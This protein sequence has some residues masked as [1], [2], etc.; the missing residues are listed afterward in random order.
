MWASTLN[1]NFDPDEEMLGSLSYHYNPKTQKVERRK[2]VN[3]VND[4]V[5]RHTGSNVQHVRL[6]FD[7]DY[8]FSSHID[9][10]I[11]FAMKKGVQVLELDFLDRGT[12]FRGSGTCYAFSH[13]VLGVKTGSASRPVCC[14]N[15]TLHP[16]IYISFKTLRV[17]HF[18]AV[19]VNGGVLEYFLSNCPLL[20]QLSVFNSPNLA[21]LRVCGPSI[22]L[23]YLAIE[24]CKALK[25]IEICDVSLVSFIYSGRKPTLLLQNIPSLVEV[26]VFQHASSCYFNEILSD[27]FTQLPCC[28]SQLEIIKAIP[29]RVSI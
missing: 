2:Y 26:S 27:V 21:K 8:K 17:L 29:S 15:P 7:L 19:A 16:N 4:V 9:K 23:K 14:D 22:A 20:E 12:L 13:E 28:L 18:K 3:W 10:W 11:Q 5:E 6:S 25:S 1:L 24:A